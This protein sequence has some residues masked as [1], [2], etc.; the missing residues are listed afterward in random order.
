VQ[1]RGKFELDMIK[2]AIK[3]SFSLISSKKTGPF[4]GIVRSKE[5]KNRQDSSE[6]YPY[7]LSSHAQSSLASYFALH[8]S[9]R[10]TGPSSKLEDVSCSFC[11]RIPQIFP[12]LK[13]LFPRSK[14]FC[15]A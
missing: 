1:S 11:L 12:L 8:D 5:K 7:Y 2:Q 9:L 13:R 4:Q 14:P 15:A 6:V 10:D 3:Y